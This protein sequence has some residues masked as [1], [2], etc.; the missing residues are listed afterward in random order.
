[1]ATAS[2]TA[3]IWQR[4]QSCSAVDFEERNYPHFKRRIFRFAKATGRLSTW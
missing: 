3:E 1:M 2:G 4:S